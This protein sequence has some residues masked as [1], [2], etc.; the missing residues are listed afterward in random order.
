MFFNQS[1]WPT[2]FEDPTEAR[3]QYHRV[4]LREARIAAERDPHR[5]T[6][7]AH[8]SLIDR[9]RGAIGLAPR[10]TDTIACGA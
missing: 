1:V 10:A 5:A 7:V 4:A 2:R 8:R 3:D 9:V 6:M